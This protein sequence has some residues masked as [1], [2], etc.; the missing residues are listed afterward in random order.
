MERRI[1]LQVTEKFREELLTEVDK[2]VSRL[3]LDLSK[4]NVMNSSGLGVLLQV[5]DKLK[6]R[7]GELVISGLNPIMQEIFSRMKLDSFFEIYRDQD[8]ALRKLQEI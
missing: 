8:K 3:V 5:R 2:G 7:S 4:V 6:N 1:F